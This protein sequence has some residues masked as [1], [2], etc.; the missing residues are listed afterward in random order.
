MISSANSVKLG[1]LRI[2]PRLGY[3]SE[4]GIWIS[5]RLLYILGYIFQSNRCLVF[6][7]LKL[8]VFFIYAQHYQGS[9]SSSVFWL[10]LE[11]ILSIQYSENSIAKQCYQV[12]IIWHRSKIYTAGSVEDIYVLIIVQST[13]EHYS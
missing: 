8:S 7:I 11:V 3:L 9:P 6:D 2:D 10:I 1:I 5:L 4:V 13:W 12:S